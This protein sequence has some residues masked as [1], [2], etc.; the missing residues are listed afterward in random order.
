MSLVASDIPLPIQQE[1][2]NDPYALGT[3]CSPP[4]SYQQ[5]S[6]ASFLICSPLN[7]RAFEASV[8]RLQWTELGGNTGCWWPFNPP[9]TELMN[10][11]MGYTVVAQIFSK[12]T[13]NYVKVFVYCNLY[14]SK[15]PDYFFCWFI[16]QFHRLH[17]RKYLSK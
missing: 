13:G 12:S 7:Y 9:Y 17:L 8:W 5:I 6:P 2:R 14:D 3:S 10:D 1:Q 15:G 4:H 16:F 11:K